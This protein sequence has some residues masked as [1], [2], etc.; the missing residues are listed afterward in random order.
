MHEMTCPVSLVILA[1]MMFVTH[2]QHATTQF[3]G[4]NYFGN[5]GVQT[6][7]KMAN[8]NPLTSH[9]LD[10]TKGRPASNVRTI[11]YKYDPTGNQ[12]VHVV[13][14]FTNKDGRV[15]NL[16]SPEEFTVGIYKIFF[17]T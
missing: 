17:D 12:W 16:I 7:G 11:V 8:A 4:N 1:V 10:T 5:T 2:S 3:S 9:I 6:P 14:Q 15:G 13:E